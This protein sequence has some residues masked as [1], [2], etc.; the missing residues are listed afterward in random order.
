MPWGV[1]RARQGRGQSK[2]ETSTTEQDRDVLNI[3]S[4]FAKLQLHA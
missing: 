4:H 1:E 3:T 2:Q